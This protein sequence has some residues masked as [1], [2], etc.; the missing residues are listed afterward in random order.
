MKTGITLFKIVPNMHVLEWDAYSICFSY[1][2]PI[3]I[4]GPNVNIISHNEWGAYTGKHL[5]IINPDKTKRV[6]HKE[7]LIALSDIYVNGFV[8]KKGPK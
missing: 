6:P 3:A 7:L 2:I 1:R 8:Y 4:Q 5:N